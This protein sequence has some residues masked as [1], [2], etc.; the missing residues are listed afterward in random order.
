MSKHFLERTDP[1][2]KQDLLDSV[3]QVEHVSQ[4]L[5]VYL[6]KHEPRIHL[7][8]M[9][10]RVRPNVSK[11][12][13]Y[14]DDGDVRAEWQDG[15]ISKH[16]MLEFKQ[17]KGYNFPSLDKF[18]YDTILVDT[19]PK[20]ERIRA[21]GDTMGYILS[22]QDM[23]CVFGID[24]DT[25]AQH[26]TIKQGQRHSRSFEYVM[27]PK[28]LFH[29]GVS[30]VSKLITQMVQTHQPRSPQDLHQE[31]LQRSL[32]LHEKKIQTLETQLMACKQIRSKLR[33]QLGHS[34]PPQTTPTTLN[35]PNTQNVQPIQSTQ[36]VYLPKKRYKFRPVKT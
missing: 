14:S 17:R 25:M 35:T 15:G 6:H 22:N 34:S 4:R 19:L 18:K 33:E 8:V 32:R 26:M 5:N 31:K 13:A 29:K 2:F 24:I 10:T 12:K 7:N 9:E 23:T 36:P 11:R 28:H 1:T 3:Q 20:F 21:R 30:N 27:I 16:A